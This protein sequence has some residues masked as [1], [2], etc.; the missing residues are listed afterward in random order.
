[1]ALYMAMEIA[2]SVKDVKSAENGL[3]LYRCTVNGIADPARSSMI[4]MIQGRRI[5][6]QTK[7]KRSIS[8]KSYIPKFVRERIGDGIKFRGI[9]G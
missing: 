1:M 2:R 5:L 8:T 4:G 6:N 3:V 9:R 7:S